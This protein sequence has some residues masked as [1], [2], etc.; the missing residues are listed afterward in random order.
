MPLRDPFGFFVYRNTPIF[1][2]KWDLPERTSS[3]DGGVSGGGGENVGARDGS[4]ATLLE[5][6]LDFVNHLE[7]SQSTAH[8]WGPLT[9][10]KVQ[11]N[12]RV[13]SLQQLL[14]VHKEL[15]KIYGHVSR[16]ITLFEQ[17]ILLFLRF[18]CVSHIAQKRKICL[19]CFHLNED[20]ANKFLWI[21]QK[22]HYFIEYYHI[23]GIMWLFVFFFF[24]L[25][26]HW[27]F[28]V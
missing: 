8:I 9:S 20:L 25:T 15:K 19:Y 2:P 10:F 16:L 28:K 3:E 11:Q 17:W 5:R 24:F 6:C 26:N 23:S 12:G 13:A 27:W 7:T 22:K 14:I 4:G 21:V 18:L 1:A